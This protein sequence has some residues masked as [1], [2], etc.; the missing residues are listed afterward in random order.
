MTD[1]HR[2]MQ[3]RL[4]S[5]LAQPNYTHHGHTDREDGDWVIW[6]SHLAPRSGDIMNIHIVKH[7]KTGHFPRKTVNT[8]HFVTVKSSF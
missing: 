8:N 4:R 3:S 1:G 5:G 2:I 6:M 7:D